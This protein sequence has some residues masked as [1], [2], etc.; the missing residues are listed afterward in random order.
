MVAVSFGSSS[1]GAE[2]SEGRVSSVIL[3]SIPSFLA[4]AVPG[5]QEVYLSLLLVLRTC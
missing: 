5:L 3:A 1:I 2:F 4:N